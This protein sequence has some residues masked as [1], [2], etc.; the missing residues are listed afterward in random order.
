MT[1]LLIFTLVIYGQAPGNTIKRPTPIHVD[2]QRPKRKDTMSKNEIEK[3]NKSILEAKD[4]IAQKDYSTAKIRLEKIKAIC[5]LKD[6]INFYLKLTSYHLK[7]EDYHNCI[8]KFEIEKAYGII[9]DVLNT[10]SLDRA[11][12]ENLFLHCKK[13]MDIKGRSDKTLPALA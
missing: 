5:N 8:N 6:T 11:T 12:V 9:T 1:L 13:L 3:V 4:L 10:Y 7:L 2:K